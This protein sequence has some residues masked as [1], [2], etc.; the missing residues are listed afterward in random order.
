MPDDLIARMKAARTFNQGF[1]SCEFLG[2]AIFDMDLHQRAA[3]APALDIDAAE[4]ACLERIGMPP[5]IGMRHR[6]THFQHITGGYAAGYYSY[7]WSEV[8]DA[9]AFHAFE[10]TGDIF[11]AATARKLH[12]HI[13][14]AGAKDEPDALYRVPRSPARHL[15]TIGKARPFGRRL[16]GQRHASTDFIG[17][18]V[19][20]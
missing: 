14:S 10:E 3:D 15:G 16:R 1:L 2:S 7:L 17:L 13:Y 6:P 20:A 19:R 5:E 4:Q 8:L 11:D 9:D 18:D 12:D